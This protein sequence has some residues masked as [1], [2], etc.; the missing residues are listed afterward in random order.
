MQRLSS[1]VRHYKPYTRR[2]QARQ[3]QYLGGRA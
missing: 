2:A 1:A 3:Q